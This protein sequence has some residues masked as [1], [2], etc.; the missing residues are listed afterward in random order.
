MD[1]A[2]VQVV[3]HYLQLI[4]VLNSFMKLAFFLQFMVLFVGIIHI[5]MFSLILYSRYSHSVN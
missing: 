3:S 5:F 4:F 2:A 1:G